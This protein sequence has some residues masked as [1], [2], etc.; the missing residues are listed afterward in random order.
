MTGKRKGNHT[1]V[2]IPFKTI[3][4]PAIAGGNHRRQIR[5]R[6]QLKRG[7]G[8]GQT[9]CG[10]EPARIGT[11]TN[12]NGC[13]RKNSCTVTIQP[14]LYHVLAGADILIGNFRPGDMAR[15]PVKRRTGQPQHGNAAKPPPGFPLRVQRFDDLINGMF[16]RLPLLQVTETW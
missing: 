1:C 9:C 4:G 11:E 13:G 14:D 10:M 8:H 16:T 12:I 2:N 7:S 15:F 3:A 6:R 5:E